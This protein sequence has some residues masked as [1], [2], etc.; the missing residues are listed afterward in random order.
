MVTLYG[1][2]NTR[3]VRVLWALQELALPYEYVVIDLFN[4]EG[5]SPEFLK[6]NPNGKV[7][8]LIDEGRVLLETGAICSYLADSVSNQSPALIP[9]AGSYQRA[10]YQQWCD[11]QLSELE[12]P[13]WMLTKNKRLYP[14]ESKLNDLAEAMGWEAR[15]AERVLS[16]GLEGQSYILGDHF[17][18]VD[19]H[20]TIS[21]V[22]N[23][24]AGF[25]LQHE[26][27]KA[28]LQRCMARPAY[29]KLQAQGE[30]S[31]FV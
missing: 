8:A 28:Y 31:A 13:A 1:A 18:I 4:G 2:P 14:K 23:M 29:T 11:F 22:W 6:L 24:S 26:N 17:S 9:E 27:V 21:L 19:I 7:P 30:L 20:M 16:K 3:T 15:R 12:V 25:P 5:Q 10:I